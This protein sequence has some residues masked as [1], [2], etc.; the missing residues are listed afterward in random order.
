MMQ[1]ITSMTKQNILIGPIHFL[2]WP[3]RFRSL[4]LNQSP[5]PLICSAV[6][7]GTRSAEHRTSSVRLCLANKELNTPAPDGGRFL[8]VCLWVHIACKPLA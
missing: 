4:R 1:R 5:V 2:N 3:L 6:M 7:S 8:E